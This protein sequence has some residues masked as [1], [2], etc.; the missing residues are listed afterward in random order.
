MPRTVLV[1]RPAPQ[2]AAWVDKLRDKGLHAQALPLMAIE[3]MADTTALREA[4][5]LLPQR[6]LAMFVS[7]NAVTSFF[8]ARPAARSWPRGL[9]AAATGPGTVEAL[10]AAGVPEALCVAPRAAPFDSTA[11]WAVLQNE[12]WVGRN[13]LVIRGD[14]GR[15]EFAQALRGAGAKIAFVQAYQRHAPDWSD[16]ECA[17]ALAAIDAPG[18]HVWLLSSAEAIDH[19]LALVGALRPGTEWKNSIAVASHPRIA[20]RARRAGFG[21]VLEAPPVVDAVLSAVGSLGDL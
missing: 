21:R 8:A 4:W 16:A 20:Q 6:D 11:L 14:G 7:P 3:P 19:L 17:L 13:A 5:H 10:L 1:T 12:D 15:D 2:A 9:R 18:Q